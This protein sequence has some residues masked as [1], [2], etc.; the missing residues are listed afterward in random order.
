[1]RYK[2]FEQQIGWAIAGN[3]AEAVRSLAGE[4][5]RV[6]RLSL[7]LRGG[8]LLGTVTLHAV[9]FAGQIVQTSWKPILVSA[10]TSR[11]WPRKLRLSVVGLDLYR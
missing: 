11:E 10:S 8:M 9:K 3:G 7:H 5:Y 1:M 4:V 6:V 2:S